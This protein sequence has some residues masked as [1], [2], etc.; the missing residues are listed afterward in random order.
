MNV[1]I[2]YSAQS[3]DAVKSLAEDIRS[4]DHRVWLDQELVGGHAWWDKILAEIRA[5]DVFAFALSPEAL[6]S[7]PC[8]LECSYAASLGKPILPV[9]IADGVMPDMLPP[10]LSAVQYVD[11][12]TP[13]RKAA[14]ALMKALRALPPAQPLPDPLPPAPALPASFLGVIRQQMDEAETLSFHEQTALVLKLKD[15]LD[16]P[17]QAAE[18]RKL[19]LKLRRRDDLYSKVADEIEAALGRDR[20]RPHV[21]EPQHAPSEGGKRT[22]EVIA[23]EDESQPKPKGRIRSYLGLAAVAFVITLFIAAAQGPYSHFGEEEMLAT[24]IVVTL[25]L[26]PVRAMLASVWRRVSGARR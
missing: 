8:R 4:L 17:A 11:Y 24:W 22:V 16:D 21:G 20:M 10:M 18:A 5:C 15:R 19:L 2:S 9:L 13:D 14:F 1:F 7:H 12:R 6:D 25:L 26:V 23:A 3:R